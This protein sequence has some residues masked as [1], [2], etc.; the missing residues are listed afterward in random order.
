MTRQTAPVAL[1]DVPP[2]AQSLEKDDEAFHQ[3]AD[4]QPKRDPGPHLPE[5]LMANPGELDLFEMFFD[6]DILLMIAAATNAYAESKKNQNP[7]M[8]RRFKLT[9]L[10]TEEIMRYIGVLLLLSLNT[11]RNYRQA[12]NIR[13]S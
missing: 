13:S 7:L 12:W 4:F 3:P 9:A 6:Q 2:V 11:T 1:N 8:Y 10:T 5:G